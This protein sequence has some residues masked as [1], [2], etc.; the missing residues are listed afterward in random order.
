MTTTT[1]FVFYSKSADKAPGKGTNEFLFENDSFDELKKNKNWRKQLSNFY[2]SNFIHDG[3]TFRTA[4]HAFHYNK[5]KLFDKNIA[6]EFTLESNSELSKGNGNDARKGRKKM[7]LSEIQLHE[8]F[9]I[10]DTIMYE[11]LQDKFTQSDDLR[12]MLLYTKNAEL[13]H[14][15]G[16]GHKK[17]ENLER[18]NH[19]ETIRFNMVLKNI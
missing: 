2:E 5:F 17:G 18:W 1:I 8:W 3:H 10:R 12:D 16:R 4:E 6:F 15:I 14:F 13:W 7:V 19:L 9:K 11:I